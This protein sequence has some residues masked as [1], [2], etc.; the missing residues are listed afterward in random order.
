VNL[1]NY[2]RTILVVLVIIAATLV[3]WF[4][5]SH[6][7]SQGPQSVNLPSSITK[8]ADFTILY[9]SNNVKG[10]D[11]KSSTLS[12]SKSNKGI[13]YELFI[14]NSQVVVSE[15]G[16]PQ[17]FGTS[18]EYANQLGQANV[19]TSFNTSAGKVSLTRPTGLDNQTVAWLV[20]DNTL[21]LAR[22]Y[23]P[24]TSSGWYL[25]FNSLVVVKN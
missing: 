6:S 14:N 7:K 25:L 12:Y 20:D 18:T 24:V 2:N 10:L 19:Y 13:I 5:V 3:G 8:Q 4:S 11:A 22:A 1:G 17:N 15:V 16:A 21:L 23:Q 9:P